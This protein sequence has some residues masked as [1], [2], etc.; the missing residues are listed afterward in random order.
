[1]NLN[2]YK[3]KINQPDFRRVDKVNS[4]RSWYEVYKWEYC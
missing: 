3:V 2:P 1:M 4:P